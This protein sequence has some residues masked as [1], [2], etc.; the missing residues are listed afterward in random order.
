MNKKEFI[1]PIL[2]IGLSIAFAVICLFVYLSK[3]KSE[4]W[5]ARKMRIGGLILT[6]SI[7]SCNGNVEHTCYETV[8]VN[9]IWFNNIGADGMEIKLDS[10]NILAGEIS[11]VQDSIYSFQIIDSKDKIVQQELLKA[12]S[13]TF[14]MFNETFKIH[15]NK[16]LTVGDYT[17]NF[18]NNSVEEQDS[19]QLIRQLTFKIKDE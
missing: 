17:I 10:S 6:L 3:G 11:G 1:A 15:L 9:H 5:L 13:G 18:F 12:D 8:A 16:Q 7:A 4:K 19:A 14:D 2:V